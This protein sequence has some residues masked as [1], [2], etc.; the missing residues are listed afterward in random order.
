M[1]GCLTAPLSFNPSS[2]KAITFWWM[3]EQRKSE[4]NLNLPQ[5]FLFKNVMKLDERW[6][7]QRRM[8]INDLAYVMGIKIILK[9]SMLF[10]EWRASC[11]QLN[12][13]TIFVLLLV[14]IMKWTAFV[15]N[16]K[17][18]AAF[19]QPKGISIDFSRILLYSNTI[20]FTACNNKH[21]P[22]YT[23][24]LRMVL[25][26]WTWLIWWRAGS[27]SWSMLAWL[28]AAD[29]TSL[30]FTMCVEISVSLLSLPSRLT[31]RSL[32]L[33]ASYSANVF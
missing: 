19:F 4:V 22:I 18:N 30:S 13:I 8:R 21:S 27:Q 31:D 33:I 7:M 1:L 11:I 20:F 17:L 26:Q 25:D 5:K 15:Q 10:P 23:H 24:I 3:K 29:R 12:D 2:E 6:W 28:M 9:V 14:I 16:N 32:F